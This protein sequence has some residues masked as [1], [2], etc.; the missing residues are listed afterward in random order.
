MLVLNLDSNEHNNLSLHGVFR[1]SDN[2]E[3][4]KIN[5]GR[6][7]STTLTNGQIVAHESSGGESESMVEIFVIP[8]LLPP[9]C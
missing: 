8:D 3:V 6:N 4:G 2:T 1:V 7:L 5:S 9:G